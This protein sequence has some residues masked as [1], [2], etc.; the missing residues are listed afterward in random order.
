MTDESDA[1][2]NLYLAGQASEAD[3]RSLGERLRSDAALR[4]ELLILAAFDAELPGALRDVA[5]EK[6]EKARV[7]V[8]TFPA[9]D[10][11]RARI[12]TEARRPFAR[13]LLWP[14]AIAAGILAV[15]GLVAY[16][17]GRSARAGRTELA[18]TAIPPPP[19][20]VVEAARPV[21]KAEGRLTEISGEVWVARADGTGQP[22]VASVGTEVFAGE[23]LRTTTNAS[24][25]FAYADGSTLSIY[26]G[27]AVVLSRTDAGPG[28][29]L[30]RGAV[31][32]DIRKQPDGRHLQILGELMH[33]E[34]VGTEFRLMVDSSSAWLGVREGKVEVT[35]VSDGQK[36]LLG[37]ANYAA[38]HP[39]WPYMK[40]NPLVCPVWKGVCQQAAGTA[41][42]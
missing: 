39:K 28:L 22:V 37:Q 6:K 11:H 24:A 38:V 1:C 17:T 23:V 21:A 10:A 40:M 12:R 20:A 36:I 15:V 42:P 34:I 13:R 7:T 31:D 30:R 35:R 5:R 25:Q 9:L 16:S 19:P 29:D 3:V 33:A 2:L 32:A 18:T 27:S 14:A 8:A 41:Y 4:K 26:R